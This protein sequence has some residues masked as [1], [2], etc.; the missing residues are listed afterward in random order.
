MI[1]KDI[2]GY[3]GLYKI[4]E[5][6][7]V[8]SVARTIFRSDG[9]TRNRKLKKLKPFLNKKGYPTVFPYKN[10][11]KTSQRVHR[12]VAITFMPNP[13]NLPQINHKD[14]NK[15]NNHVSNLEWCTNLY[16]MRHSHSVIGRNMAKGQQNR[17]SRMVIDLQTG[18]FYE[19]IGEISRAKG[20]SYGAML[21]MLN[22]G[23]QNFAFC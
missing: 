11:V 12:L 19:T 23:S 22:K 3:D 17:R 7:N 5:Y 13:Q 4:D 21:W 16:N 20:I 6:G 8:I 1:L 15:M 9:Q 18:I 14:G 2:P 10:R